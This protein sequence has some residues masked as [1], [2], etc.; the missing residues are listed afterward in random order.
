MRCILAYGFLSENP[1]FAEKLNAQ[2]II[3]IGPSAEAI[4][5]MGLKDAAKAVMD[6]AGVPT[7]PGYLGEDQSEGTLLKEAC[8]IG[9]PIFDPKLWRVVVEKACVTCL[10]KA[11]LGRR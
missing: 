8:R 7:V 1:E 6:N 2:G 10:P 3:F 5:T 9:F 4:R 11:I